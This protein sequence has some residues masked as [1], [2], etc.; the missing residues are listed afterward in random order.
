MW[1]DGDDRASGDGESSQ[2]DADQKQTM[3]NETNYR[4]KANAVFF[5]A[6]MVVSMVAVGFAAAPAAAVTATTADDLDTSDGVQDQ[7]VEFTVQSADYTAG[8][9][10]DVTA[11]FDVTDASS[12]LSLEGVTL[13]SDYNGTDVSD[14]VSAAVNGDQV[15]VSFNS[16]DVSGDIDINVTASVDASDAT[17]VSP[18]NYTINVGGNTA[19]TSDFAITT[20]AGSSGDYDTDEFFTG[21]GTDLE[22]GL[23]WQGQSVG[24]TGLDANTDIALRED[25][26]TD[27]GSRLVEQLSTDNTG[28]VTFDTADLE[29]GDYYL[30]GASSATAKGTTFEVAIQSLSTEFDEDSV[31]S[32][33][34]AEFDID[35]NRGTYSLNVSANGD[36]DDEELEALFD[37]DFD[38]TIPDDDDEEIVTLNDV[39]DDT[40]V[41]NFSNVE[42]LDTGEYEFTFESVDTS[43]EDTASIEVTEAGEGEL[44][45]AEG[46]TSV[47]QGDIAE[48]TVELDETD[49]GSVVIGNFDDDNYQANISVEDGNDDG[50]VTVL[51]NTYTAGQDGGTVVE[52]EAADDDDEAN[53][54]GE[55]GDLSELL[56]TGD[57]DISVSPTT[58]GDDGDATDALN[59]ESDIGSLLIEERSTGDMVLWRTTDD[60]R[61]DVV[62]VQND[63]NASAAVGAIVGGV[64]GGVVT[65]TD[66]LA[67]GSNDDSDVLVHQI[68]ASGLEGALGNDVDAASLHDLLIDDAEGDGD[69]D[70]NSLALT[71]TEQDPGANAEANEIN[72]ADLDNGEFT[73]AV[74]VVYDEENDDY[75][76]FLDADEL[77]SAID[78]NE[79]SNFDDVETIGDGDEYTVEFTVQNA[80]LTGVAEDSDYSDDDYEDAFESANATFDAVEADGSFDLN[81]DDEVEV[82]NTEDANISGTMNVAPGTEISLRVRSEDAEANFI[83]NAEEIVVQQ[84]GTFS[85][86]FDFSEESVNDTFTVTTRNTPLEEEL[87]DDGVVI[88]QVEEPDDDSTTDDDSTD[89]DSTDDDS[90][91]EDDSTTDDDSTDDDSSS[92]DD[93]SADDSSSEDDSSGDDSSTEDDTPGFGAIVALVALIAAALLATR[94]NE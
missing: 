16:S 4:T 6:I 19:T 45:L 12:D 15:E 2:R 33:E 58:L 82:E 71:L 85:A 36:L 42:D 5:A 76:V 20:T 40:F 39:N 66:T 80:K 47:A 29:S 91:T 38:V 78:A 25:F 62:E 73:S 10:S 35:S 27:E 50:E 74:D 32:D 9:D 90:S 23:I 87:E 37:D 68:T 88:E 43:A 84:D 24:V 81:D 18:V 52:A 13:E 67:L 21:T 3:T 77:N 86:S 11:T 72:L 94:R 55:Q 30:V 17:A 1:I 54:D 8:D 26:G 28:T 79:N 51:F 49:A 92:E 53:L 63:E 31:Q 44:S 59:D 61:D 69:D 48:I 22:G 7:T 70:S 14:N 46:S 65:E 34:E 75:Y 56:D 60:V 89:D 83:K 41:A 57:Y 93:S 64:E